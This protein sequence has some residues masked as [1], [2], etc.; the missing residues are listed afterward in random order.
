MTDSAQLAANG[1]QLPI[2]THRR[3]L[4]FQRR[5]R[6]IKLAEGV[7]AAIFGLALSYL[8]VFVL[9]R[10]LDTPGWVRICILLLG[11][12]GCG[13]LLP[14]K[15][16]RWIWGTRR[17]EQVAG[18][19]RQTLPALGDQLLGVVELALFEKE[20]IRNSAL[21]RA[22]IAQVDQVMQQRDLSDAVPHPRH[23]Q[24]LK[25]AAVP[26][27]L[28][29]LCLTVLPAAGT[30][31]LARWL[32][33]WKSIERY[34]FAQLQ[35]LPESIVV[36]QG[37]S[38]ELAAELK[39]ESPWTPAK[40]AARS[41]SLREEIRTE[42]QDGR[43]AF[44]LPALNQQTQ[45]SLSIGDARKSLRIEPAPRPELR[46]M[47]ATL[48]LPAYLQ[49]P[50]PLQMDVRGGMLTVVEGT[51]LDV[52][53]TLTR[54]LQA[55]TS[56]AGQASIDG[57][58]LL[59]HAV[60][61]SASEVIRLHWVDE[62][63]LSPR[64]DFQL[65]INAVEDAEPNVFL[66]QLNPQQVVLS[67][68]TISFELSAEDDFGLKR[69]G[70]TWEGI[71]DPLR[72]PEPEQGQKVQLLGSPEERRLRG[73]VTFNAATE[74]VKPQPLKLRA[75]A[76][77]YHPERGRAYSPVYVVHVLSPE[78]HAIW[79]ANQLRRWAS[80]ADDVYEEEV[81][82]HD[83]NRELR[84]MTTE[85][86]QQKE[87]QQL[88]RGQ[89]AA[90]R[91]NAQRL[92]AVTAQGE[93]LIQ[94]AIRNPEMLAGHLELW[95][96]ALQQLR[97]MADNRM[98][99]V[100]DLLSEAQQ[101]QAGKK[102]DSQPSPPSQTKPGPNVGN[103]RNQQAGGPGSPSEEEP[104]E[105]VQ[106]APSISDVESGFNTPDEQ[107]QDEQS[108]EKKKPSSGKLTLP[109]TV[110]MGGP[111]SEQ[112]PNDDQPDDDDPLDKA[113]EDQAQLIEDFNK[114]REDLQAIL[115]D[116]ENSTFVKRFKAAARQ[117][118][119]IA[120]SLNRT[121]FKGFGVS[122]TQLVQQQV[123]QLDNI[124]ESEVAQSR[125]VWNLQS[126]LEAYY[127]RKRDD[128]FK[129]ILD[130]MKSLDPTQKLNELSQLVRNNLSG[131][132]IVHAEF[133][134]DTFD[135][136]A[137]ELVSVSECGN[138][139]GGE[140]PSLPPGII[141][142]VMRI[143]EGEMDLREETRG[144]EQGRAAMPR[145]EFEER[146]E[147]QTGTQ[148]DLLKRTL[149]VVTD[150]QALPDG[151]ENFAKEIDIVRS[152]A[153][154]MNDARKLLSEQQTGPAT[155]AAETEAIELLLASKRANPNSGGGGGGGSTPG[156]GGEGDTQRAALAT[157]GT[158][159]DARTRVERREVEQA[160]GLMNDRLPEE[161]REGLDAF[162]NALESR[163]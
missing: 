19:V 114:I 154:A 14:L 66:Q 4:E 147:K 75:F 59:V 140:S 142:E 148:T 50:Q 79:I 86:L 22:A 144:L 156:G 138:C 2:A 5:V 104:T 18:L 74:G 60:P 10:F 33:P 108:D 42:L 150:I 21:T 28:M 91:A 99:S 107:Q 102:P 6:V 64:D 98:P 37:E 113:V 87:Q 157:L 70:L 38:F 105:P 136:W 111:K 41:R 125:N 85:E 120:Q 133:W 101:A 110:L 152:A 160:S 84:Q 109:Q 163:N 106:Q 54:Q 103:Q 159:S 137:E 124:A 1:E 162:F 15:C 141:L 35:P 146:A 81:R 20:Q 126:D 112:K 82:L 117:Q 77:D 115:N 32:F 63:G 100:A 92:D 7:L 80:L 83:A 143:I 132:S 62:L 127:G 12:I 71:H 95:A 119:E 25:Y 96:E 31:A 121:L 128:K 49:Y 27:G 129:R 149:D 158:T 130:D 13:V 131:E 36:P 155:I 116:L 122:G 72:N 52:A 23:R 8:A 67:T 26:V 55:G 44:S 46:E 65:K 76:E 93:A 88:L 139:K 135:R 11:G 48:H 34:T 58:H 57:D 73:T 51:Q 94:Q 30:N 45:V 145:E 56:S 40:G 29:L 16:H 161:F 90:E 39:P 69:A 78:Q 123:S 43:Y 151:E 53:A 134:A 89:A 61:V 17:M 97:D 68:E 3:L 47:Q 9:D 153:V 24:W 118:L